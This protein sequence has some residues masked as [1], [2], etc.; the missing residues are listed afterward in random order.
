MSIDLNFWK[1]K[2]GMKLDSNEVYQRV[3]CN[4]EEIEGLEHLPIEAIRCV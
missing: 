4:G 3:C 1:C 2:K